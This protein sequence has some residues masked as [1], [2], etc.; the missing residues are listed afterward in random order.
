MF[1]D[2]LA[3][4]PGSVHDS[5]IWKISVAGMYVENTFSIGEHILGDSGYML[6]PIY[7]LVIANQYPLPNLTITMH[8]IGQGLL[9][10]SHLEDG[11]EDSTVFMGISG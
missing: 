5:R 11:N 2:V 1:S 6:R 3:H 4:F 8:I 10:N 7:S 9:L